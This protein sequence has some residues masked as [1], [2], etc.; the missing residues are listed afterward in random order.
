ML[1]NEHFLHADEQ[2][3]HLFIAISPYMQ[4]IDHKKYKKQKSLLG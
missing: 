2:N 1:E 3:S 4:N